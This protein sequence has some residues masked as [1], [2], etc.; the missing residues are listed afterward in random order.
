VAYDLIAEL[1][2]ALELGRKSLLQLLGRVASDCLLTEV[3][4]LLR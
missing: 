4:Y 1:E 3:K 2:D